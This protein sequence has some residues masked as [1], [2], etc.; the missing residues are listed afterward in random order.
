MT[1]RTSPP[2]TAY[3]H[4][5]WLLGQIGNTAAEVQRT[6]AA[7]SGNSFSVAEVRD[8]LAGPQG[9]SPR[10][11]ALRRDLQA[12]GQQVSAL[13]PRFLNDI[14]II[15]D[16]DALRVANQR[17]GELEA[18]LP[19][20]RQAQVDASK[21]AAG[22]HFLPSGAKK[23][24]EAEE[25]AAQAIAQA[26]TA[27]DSAE[28]LVND[29]TAFAPIGRDGLAALGELSEGGQFAEAAR[30]LQRFTSMWSMSVAAGANLGDPSWLRGAL[31]L[32]AAIQWWRDVEADARAVAERALVD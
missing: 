17:I 24:R 29:V 27:R 13:A 1:T 22:F 30:R 10:V 26:E 16:T 12:L 21:R 4:F 20:L 25:A 32:P 14:N 9:L 11:E 2:Q 3:G 31:D 7:M 19:D 15:S 18:R 8:L 28:K 6:L 23:S 5:V